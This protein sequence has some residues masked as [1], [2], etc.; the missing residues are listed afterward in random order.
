MWGVVF[1][2]CVVS[3]SFTRVLHCFWHAQFAED[4]AAK[5]NPDLDLASFKRRVLILPD[6]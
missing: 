1:T 4:E 3:F 6:M 5:Q 2:A